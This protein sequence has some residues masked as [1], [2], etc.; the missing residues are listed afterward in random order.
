MPGTL[1]LTDFAS[2]TVKSIAPTIT[3]IAI[4]GVRQSKQI[5][6]QYWEIDA[7][8]AHLDR[9]E[10]AR[11]MG[12]LSKQRNSLYSFS[13]IVPVLSNTAGTVATVALANPGDS[14]VMT[15][16]A[17]AATG[18]S[19]VLFDTAYNSAKFS[20]A[21]V[22]ASEGLLAG[23]FVKFSN[24][25]K[26]YQLIEDVAFNGSGGGTL[27]FFPNLTDAVTTSDTV[28]YTSVPFT[29]FSK[30]DTQEYQYGIG[31]ENS[32]ELSLQEAL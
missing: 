17:N 16:T 13:L 25:N 12:F 2:V 20:A 9:K 21:G 7:E 5:A 30:N 23:D 15:I 6:G 14:T 27:T 18:A 24:H 32:V 31:G 11:V 10:F 26:V 22:S 29:V 1:T 19:T 4:S 8:Y 28:V 3:T